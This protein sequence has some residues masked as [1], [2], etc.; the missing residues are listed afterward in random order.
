[1]LDY[2]MDDKTAAVL[3]EL[4]QSQ[5]SLVRLVMAVVY[6]VSD[7]RLRGTLTPAVEEVMAHLENAVKILNDAS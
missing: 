5:A 4:I 7:E 3:G 6:S 1:M 2:G